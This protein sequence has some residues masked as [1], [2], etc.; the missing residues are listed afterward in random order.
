MNKPIKLLFNKI[1][2][3]I[4]CQ[5]IIL[6]LAPISMVNDIP[7][8]YYKSEKVPTKFHL[9]GLFE[10][11]MGWHFG[12]KDRIAIWKDVQSH[13]KKKFK[14]ELEKY[15]SN[16]GFQPLIFH[17]FEQGVCLH[18]Q[19]KSFDDL[20]KKAFRRSDA[21]VHPNGTPNLDHS[22]IKV[23]RSLLR[24]DKK[25][26]QPNDNEMETL[27]KENLGKFPLYYSTLATREYI[28]PSNT[29]L[30]T[31]NFDFTSYNIKISLEENLYNQIN[32]SLIENSTGYL[33]TSDGW[34]EV[35][36]IKL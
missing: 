22:L 12:I 24:K 21:I 14:I 36:L 18:P 19:M 31:N 16:S 32:T 25:P 6:P 9:C 26:Q 11:L 27:F 17:L 7:G 3:F 13:Q 28:Y 33:G 30:R 35:K 20:W 23:K 10:N 5:L 8:S 34:V 2:Q 29:G 1:N 4:D 15:T